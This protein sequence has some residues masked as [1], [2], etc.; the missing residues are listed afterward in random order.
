VLGS[1]IQTPRNEMLK[2]SHKYGFGNW[3]GSVELLARRQTSAP[4]FYGAAVSSWE[5]QAR[6]VTSHPI[7]VWFPQL[8]QVPLEFLPERD[9]SA[10]I[11]SQYKMIEKL[12]KC[13]YYQRCA[14]NDI[15]R[16][17]VVFLNFHT[18]FIWR[19]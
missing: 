13:Q 3:T 6:W 18:D 1:A 15:L 9:G 4:L 2:E 16:F 17:S 5:Y 19:G 7:P 14:C 8:H 12:Q 10:V 11:C